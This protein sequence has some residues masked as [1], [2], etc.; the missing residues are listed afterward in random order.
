MR[1]RAA[2]CF[3]F[4]IA[5]V[6]SPRLLHA[7]FQPPT[8]ED[9]QMTED[10]KAPGAAAVYLYREE[11]TDDTLHYNSYFERIKVLTEKGKELAT[12]RISYERNNC[13]V[14]NIQGRTIHSDG[15]IIPLIARPS[16]LTDEKTAG[17][18]INT[19]V[20]TLPSVE[21]GSILEYRL[22]LSYDDGLV[23][24]PHWTVQQPYF[25][26]KAHYS[27]TPM[28]TGGR[29]ITNSRGDNLSRLMYSLHAGNGSKVVEDTRGRFIFD[30]TD[31]P[32]R[33]AEDWLP[34]LNSLIWRVQFYYTQYYSG[35]EFWQSE[36]KRWGK[37][38]EKFANPTKTLQQAAVGIV[39]PNDAND[40]KARKIYTAVMQLD[41]TSFSR[42]K[43]AAER[44]N[45][46]LKD[47]KNAED[48]WNQKSGSSNDLAL[49]YVA[50]AR[51]AG[52]QAWPIQVVD[53]NRAVFDP[54]Y[55]TI[56][57]FDDYLAIVVIGGKEVFLDPGQKECPF[58]LLHW[59]HS[60]TAG[61]RLSASGVG[62]GQT[63]PS[64]Y[65]QSVMSRVADLIFD[66]GGNVTGN[67]RFVMSGAE[68]LRWRQLLLENDPDEVKRQF[69]E[70]IRAEIPDGVRADFDH[71]LGLEDYN[72]NLIGIV[73]VTGNIGAATGKRFFL[74]GLFFESRARHPFIAENKRVTPI[75]VQ[76]PRTEQDDITYHLPPGFDVESL[77]QLTSL[78]WPN[79]ALM[80]IGSKASGST[81]NI[82]RVMAYNYT[83]LDPKDYTTLHEFYQKV[84]TADQQQLVLTRTRLAAK[85]N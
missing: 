29:Y 15:T 37:E 17:H 35:A 13:K 11:T 76:Y 67:V 68:A 14:T 23:S 10:P 3:A 77:P 81:V 70:S 82:T 36:G 60:L 49:L 45:E 19:V 1:I 75:D 74:P 59:K 20:F 63:P 16:D 22:N 24:S 40:Q 28:S 47:I 66:A 18:Q 27:F 42:E 33:P 72:S 4:V 85:G 73:K 34:P 41:N 21:V 52:L 44:K 2:L 39:D 79:L 6:Q 46:K 84:A 51:A 53:R 31:V 48:V 25:V 61:L 38:A 57:Q 32:P 12:V 80:K 56:D 78:S 26:H 30:I 83:L 65:Q 69:N 54:D 8:K 58:G 43:S 55:L 50:L 7:Q 9:L 71:F 64:T 62:L 5:T